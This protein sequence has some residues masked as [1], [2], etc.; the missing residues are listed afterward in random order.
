MTNILDAMG[1][2]VKLAVLGA[3]LGLTVVYYGWRLLFT[4]V[5]PRQHLNTRVDDTVLLIFY[6]SL[7]L[8]LSIGPK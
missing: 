1:L 6:A 4:D 8:W 7:F 3:W 2:T 5:Y